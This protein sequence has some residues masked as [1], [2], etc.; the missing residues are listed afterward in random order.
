VVTFGFVVCVT[1]VGSQAYFYPYNRKYYQHNLKNKMD[2]KIPE[3]LTIEESV[4]LMM[5]VSLGSHFQ[6]IYEKLSEIYADANLTAREYRSQSQEKVHLSELEHLENIAQ[7]AKSRVK[8]AHNIRDYLTT[9]CLISKNPGEKCLLKIATN[10]P[11]NL[12][13]TK[14]SVIDVA[15]TVFRITIPSQPLP[16][17]SKRRYK[18]TLLDILDHAVDGQWADGDPEKHPTNDSLEA[19]ILSTYPDITWSAQTLAGF[20]KIIR[21]DKHRSA[22][23]TKAIFKNPPHTL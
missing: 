20:Y 19:W 17:K 16:K 9:L 15:Y 14:D 23:E 2:M 7:I 3:A 1:L 11:G 5:G 22:G 6:S 13:L 4:S 18:S 10:E 8:Q 12:K 21:P